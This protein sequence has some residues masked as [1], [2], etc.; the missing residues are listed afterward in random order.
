VIDSLTIDPTDDPSVPHSGFNLDPFFSGPNDPDGCQHQ[1]FFSDV[2]PDQNCPSVAGDM[3]G[4]CVAT[5]NPGC[6]IGTASCAGGVDNQLP[7]L[8]A[9]SAMAV[10]HDD[11][12]VT[13]SS[14]VQQNALSLIIRVSNVTD[15]VNATNLDVAVFVAFPEFG[16]HCD[17]VQ[18]GRTYQISSSSVAS[19][20][21]AMPQLRLTGAIVNGRLR[22]SLVGD[23]ALPGGGVAL[24]RGN[25]GGYFLAA[26]FCAQVLPFPEPH[27]TCESIFGSLVDVQIAGVCV[28]YRL[29]QVVRLGALGV[30][31]R[32]HAVAAEIDA[33]NPVASMRAPGSCGTAVADGGAGG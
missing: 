9:I 16:D 23:A 14:A 27:V 33:T 5:P 10:W 3:T 2:D 18:P 1:D 29:G 6:T 4:N 26:D 13:V 15:E 11:P 22:A 21:V 17:G 8:A 25:V 28:E 24:E 12:H 30:G 19:G 31:M 32:F 20:D 7:T